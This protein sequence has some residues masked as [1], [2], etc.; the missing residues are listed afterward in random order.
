MNIDKPSQRI[1][2]FAKN[3]FIDGPAQFLVRTICEELKKVKE[4]GYIFGD[5]IDPYQRVDYQSSNFPA[6][7]VYNEL[8]D[9][10]F[11][12]WWVTGHVL[13]DVI[14]PA[15]IRRNDLQLIPDQICAALLQQFRRPSFFDAVE[16]QVPGLN[17]LGKEFNADKS[18]AF[19]WQDGMLPLTQISVNFR[20]DLR[21][22]DKYLDTQARTKDEP[23]NITLEQLKKIGTQINLM[24]E[25]FPD[26]TGQDIEIRVD[27][28]TNLPKENE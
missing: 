3:P 26:G 16:L 5:F 15:S 4:F 21:E 24:K 6:L 2:S 22:W 1:E 20:V 27:L 8:Y 9:K 12:S 10:Q 19:I 7:R 25:Q 17:E 11:E 18:L 14:Y 28:E 13:L 23:F